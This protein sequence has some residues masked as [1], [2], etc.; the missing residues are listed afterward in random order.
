MKLTFKA[1]RRA[2]ASTVGVALMVSLAACGVG[3]GGG[4]SATGQVKAGNCTL[5]DQVSN[6]KPLEGTPTGEITFQTTALKQSFEPYFNEL[7]KAF[8]DKYPGTTVKWQDDPGDSSFTQRLVTD[9]Q[10]CQLPDVVNLN[11]QTAY[12][13][14]KENFLLN[15]SKKA[16]QYGG[17]FI[18]SIWNSIKFHGSEDH[19]MLPWYWG[20]TGIQIYNKALLTKAGLDPAKPP[21]TVMEQFD[22]AAQIAKNSGGDYFA[23]P[24]NP[25]SRVPSDWQVMDAQIMNTDQT[26]FTFASDPKVVTWLTRLAELYQAGAMPKDTL[27]S[28]ADVTKLY[29]AGTVAWGSNVLSFLRYV[30]DT[31]EK[32]YNTSAVAPLLDARG[33]AFQE[34]QFISVASTSKNPVTALAFAQFMLQTEWQS[35]FVADERVAI[36]PS[37]PDSFKISKFTKI[38]TSTPLGQ[39]TKLSV[40]LAQSAENTFLFNWSDAVQ[41]AVVAEL[42]KALAGSKQP[43]EA[44]D[45]AQKAANDVLK[46]Q[47][48]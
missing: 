42:Q 33:K 36:F 34:G 20:L 3:G 17:E 12:A 30:K 43:Q 35:K 8:Q 25:A 23:F 41:Q 37:T 6:D 44:L 29:S 19:F 24:A 21:T 26:E 2:A 48:R 32:V 10:T 4:S 1:A 14:F 28:D 38:D 31:N 27:S 18:P 39:A 11:Q 9:A 16:P 5:S 46:R 45:A 7:I 40:D 22:Q 47:N 15:F 13:L